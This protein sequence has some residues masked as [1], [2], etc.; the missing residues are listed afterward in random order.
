MRTHRR[1]V[2]AIPLLVAMA[3]LTAGPVV[4]ATPAAAATGFT[5][6]PIVGVR[7]SGADNCGFGPIAGLNCLVTIVLRGDG[8]PTAA[9]ASI[10]VAVSDA[11]AIVTVQAN[12]DSGSRGWLAG[13]DTDSFSTC[14]IIIG[15]S[16]S[17]ELILQVGNLGPTCPVNAIHPGDKIDVTLFN[18]DGSA[19]G[20]QTTTATAPPANPT[21]PSDP[22]SPLV[23]EVVPPYGPVRGGTTA[24]PVTGRVTVA[25]SDVGT[26]EAA[27]F[28][29]VA[30]SD[31][32]PVDATH[33]SVVPPP[34]TAA[35]DNEGIAVQFAD[36]VNGL[37][38]QHCAVLLPDGCAD[39]FMYLS[40]HADTF[41]SPPLNFNWNASL[42]N[43]PSVASRAC[44]VN[45]SSG[46][47]TGL[48]IGGSVTGGPITVSANYGVSESAF[49][50]PETFVG[51]ATFTVDNPISINVSLK[52]AVSGCEQIAIPDLAIPGIAGLYFVVGGG[53]EADL[54]L[55]ITINKGTY[56]IGG[57]FI[58]G[59]NPGDVRGVTVNAACVDENDQPAAECVT[60][61]LQASLTGTLAISPL[62]L[63]IGPDFANVGAGLTAQAIGTITIPP[64]SVDGDICVAGNWVAQVNV[65]PLSGNTGGTW[66][67]PFN[68]AGNG[69]LCPLGDASSGPAST[70]T[71][72][73]SSVNPSAPDQEVTLTAS[74]TPTPDGGTVS[75]TDN[76]VAIDACQS[77]AVDASGNAPCAVTLATAG[78]HP[79]VATYSG[80]AAFA[81]SASAPLD[82]V[83][84][85][86]PPPTATT[87]AL[88]SSPN[89]SALN[90]EVTYTASV[91]PTP[92]GGTVSFTD[93]GVAIDACQSVALDAAGN[94][95]CAVTYTTAG[96]HSIV[97]TYSGTAAF[98]GSTAT[99]LDQVVS[100]APPPT[101]TATG[102]VSSAN[103]SALNEAVTYTASVSPVPDGGTVSFTDDGAPIAECPDAVVDAAGEA[104]CT[105]TYTAAG[106]HP[107]VATYNGD[108]AFAGSVSSTLD[109]VVSDA[110]PPTP[111]ATGLASS[112]N[113]SGLNEAV[114]YTASVSPTPDG[115]TVS[116][117][118]DG[119]AIAECQDVAV[120]ASGDAT[121]AVTYTAAGSHPIVATYSG[122]AAFAGSVSS[123][124]DQVVSDAPPP[125]ATSTAVGIVGEPVGTRR[126]GHA[127]GVGDSDARWWD[128]VV[129]R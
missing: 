79:I 40:E 128:G 55:I 123:T 27:W 104:T 82:Q 85:D 13:H 21:P 56:S 74:V 122:D 127:D 71:G 37:S 70:S 114:T 7:D 118:D 112:P 25:T 57:S 91:G 44:G 41:T 124:L 81:G 97:A 94:A 36:S 102:L 76:G 16:T 121:C 67:G 100:D 107:I 14:K 99:A 69:A 42:V 30:T 120:D 84:S 28:G 6:L 64:G 51:A 58:P 29:A 72:L 65:G 73:A 60:T 78:S 62:W 3:A 87:T 23:S 39:Q 43:S 47:S 66:L 9:P 63:Q 32:T 38:P 98:A 61:K 10:G 126:A 125:T 5:M 53:I 11:A 31:I 59:S 54:S 111:T 106:S 49:G 48:S 18:P 33:F 15:A 113:P 34:S 103:P 90:E 45:G 96:S 93:N 75:F 50:F 117:T 52:G 110:P 88:S 83:V 20:T 116:F 2:V 92:D 46:T 1:R 109:Q 86:A 68:I 4:T 12:N 129:H 105:V 17:T 115:G 19:F 24:E 8:L 77:V 80:D 101:P 119:A 35:Q 26:P 89:P 95:P 22:I 108:A